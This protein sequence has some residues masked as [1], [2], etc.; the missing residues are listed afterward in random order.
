MFLDKERTMYNVQ[1]R[2]ICTNVPS[3]QILD[4]IYRQAFMSIEDAFLILKLKYFMFTLTAEDCVQN[5]AITFG[6]DL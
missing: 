5:R 1:K 2:N 6:D 4:L 3:S